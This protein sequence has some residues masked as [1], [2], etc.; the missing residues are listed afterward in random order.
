M[1][2]GFG[3]R[4]KE[5]HKA[6][7]LESADALDSLFYMQYPSKGARVRARVNEQLRRGWH[8]DLTQCVLIGFDRTDRAAVKAITAR[9]NGIFVFIMR[10][11]PT[12]PHSTHNVPSMTSTPMSSSPPPSTTA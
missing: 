10:V 1:S 12:P 5:H 7:M 11:S 9:K 2:R 3:T 4:G 8:E 6:S